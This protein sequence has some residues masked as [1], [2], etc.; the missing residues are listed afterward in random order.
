MR[1]SSGADLSGYNNYWFPVEGGHSS[2]AYTVPV[3]GEW[4]VIYQDL[5]GSW[6]GW[7]NYIRYD[8]GDFSLPSIIPLKSTG[9]V[10][11][12]KRVEN[13]GFEGALEPGVAP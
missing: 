12:T 6:D 2:L 8:F 13:N 4:F 5:S 11:L 7:F 9:F 3:E 10:S 1:I